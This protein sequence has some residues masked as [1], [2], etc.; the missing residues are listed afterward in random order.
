[1]RSLPHLGLRLHLWG[2]LREIQVLAA[3]RKLQLQQSG[4][5]EPVPEELGFINLLAEEGR[6]VHRLYFLVRVVP[7]PDQPV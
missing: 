2:G 6:L 7:G 3:E 5:L 1:M 4:K